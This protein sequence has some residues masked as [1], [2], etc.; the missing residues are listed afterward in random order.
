MLNTVR[1]SK[2]LL[3][4]LSIALLV[5]AAAYADD[6]SSVSGSFT[7]NGKESKLAYIS[8]TKGEPL[9]DKPTIQIIMTEKDHSKAKNV[10]MKAGFGDFGSA[11]IITVFHDGKVCGCEVAHEA[12]ERKPFS[13]IGDIATSDFKIA[14]GTITGKL[15]TTKELDTFRQKWQVNLAFKVKAP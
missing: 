7:G 8:A 6:A 12:H 11:L 10:S 13:S 3:G 5:T 4:C 2:R 1:F 15:A 9:S 14:N